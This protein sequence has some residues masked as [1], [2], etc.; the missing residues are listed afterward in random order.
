MHIL[1]IN[2]MI[3]FEWPRMLHE[4]IVSNFLRIQILAT[5]SL[6]WHA[7]NK[8]QPTEV[9]QKYPFQRCTCTVRQTESSYSI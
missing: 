1:D 8:E 3:Y 6:I 9:Q 7:A 2:H 4:K 5:L